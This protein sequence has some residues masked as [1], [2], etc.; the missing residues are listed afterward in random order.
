MHQFSSGEPNFK[1]PFYILREALSSVKC[2]CGNADN[3]VATVSSL[4][5]IF[6]CFGGDMSHLLMSS[7]NEPLV[8]LPGLSTPVWLW[9]VFFSLE[10]GRNSKIGLNQCSTKERPTKHQ[11]LGGLVFS[12]YIYFRFL[13]VK[14]EGFAV[15]VKGE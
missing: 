10:Y 15:Y 12:F 1:S 2:R 3:E 6:Y 9:I 11:C 14:G 7:D 4:S 13:A 8:M 5:V